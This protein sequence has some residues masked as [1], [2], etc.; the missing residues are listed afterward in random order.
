[1]VVLHDSNFVSMIYL[2]HSHFQK[3]DRIEI[4]TKTPFEFDWWEGRCNGKV[5]IFPANYVKVVA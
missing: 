2:F 3:N 1:M 4:L 5:G